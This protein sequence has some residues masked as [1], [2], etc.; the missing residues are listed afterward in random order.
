MSNFA[1]TT[2]I[3]VIVCQKLGPCPLFSVD[4]H[5]LNSVLGDCWTFNIEK[6]GG[7]TFQI[8]NLKNSKIFTLIMSM[9][10][11]LKPPLPKVCS[12]LAQTSSNRF[13]AP[14]LFLKYFSTFT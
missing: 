3:D 5:S 11:V 4:R 10:V 6:G 7:G 8:E 2:I 14:N 13:I 9:I 12:K 1:G